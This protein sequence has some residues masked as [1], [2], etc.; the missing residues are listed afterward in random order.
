M[1]ELTCQGC[2]RVIPLGTT[3]YS[4]Q[5]DV[6]SD[7]DGFLPDFEDIEQQVE[8]TFRQLDALNEKDLEED[9][10]LELRMILCRRCRNDLVKDLKGIVRDAQSGETG[11]PGKLQ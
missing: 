4:V 9:V 7:F 5:V 2:G 8:R 3:R 6:R 10:H 11:A 1:I